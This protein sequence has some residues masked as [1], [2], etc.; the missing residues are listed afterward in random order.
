MLTLRPFLS[1]ESDPSEGTSQVAL[2]IKSL[3]VNV[4][5]IRDSGWIPGWE[6]HP[7][8]GCGSPLQYSCLENLMDRGT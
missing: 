5:D 7:G 2:V 3:S 8:G 1:E 6:R 4:G